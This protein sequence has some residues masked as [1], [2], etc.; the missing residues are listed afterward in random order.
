MQ[1]NIIITFEGTINTYLQKFRAKYVYNIYIHVLM[2]KYRRRCSSQ[3]IYRVENI[4][5]LVQLERDR[6]RLEVI[7]S[8]S[9]QN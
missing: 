6:R 8:L 4:L 5:E 1:K 7:K 9:S 3:I 2:I